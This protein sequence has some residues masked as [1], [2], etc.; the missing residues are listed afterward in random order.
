LI[1]R[2]G[3]VE[4]FQNDPN[5]MVAHKIMILYVIKALDQD[6]HKTNLT[7]F[8]MLYDYM[9]F[10]EF[11]QYLTELIETGLVIEIADPAN[12]RC[13]ITDAG[14]NSLTF[15]ND[16]LDKSTKRELDWRI[17][18]ERSK[19]QVE[20]KPEGRYI[21]ESD[22]YHFAELKI[23]SGST[24]EFYLKIMVSDRETAEALISRW[25]DRYDSMSSEIAAW[26]TL[27]D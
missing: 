23:L 14:L 26:R 22:H 19:K 21:K 2:I 16:R 13:I 1:T 3:G 6:V 11:Q 9:N 7:D 24:L 5:Q 8:F 25:Y 4:V 18:I 17:E 12:T 20:R 15:F 10:F 27:F